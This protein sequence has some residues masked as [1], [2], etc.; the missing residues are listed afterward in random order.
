MKK[1]MQQHRVRGCK[2]CLMIL[3]ASICL[4]TGCSKWRDSYQKPASVSMDHS[5]N[6]GIEGYVTKKEDKRIL[7]VSTKLKDFSATGGIKEF[8]DAIWVSKAPQEIEVGQKVQVWFEGAIASSYPGQGE[9]SK[10]VIIPSAYHEGAVM[11]EA[12]AVQQAIRDNPKINVFVVNQ[13]EFDPKLK[14][15]TIL[16]K[17]GFL[18]GDEIEQHSYQFSDRRE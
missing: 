3:L 8:Y 10:V 14:Q 18:S 7:V 16:Y 5:N 11:S 9:A 12:Q 13:L 17:D 6:V 1:K 4:L 15:W 2:A